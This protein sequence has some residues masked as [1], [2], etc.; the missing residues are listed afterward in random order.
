M[1]YCFKILFSS[2]TKLVDSVESLTFTAVLSVKRFK[3]RIC[4]LIKYIKLNMFICAYTVMSDEWNA[5]VV[6]LG[7]AW[8]YGGFSFFDNCTGF[9]DL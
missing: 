5:S 4:L 8:S 6:I 2:K 3:I 9:C 1:D 7:V